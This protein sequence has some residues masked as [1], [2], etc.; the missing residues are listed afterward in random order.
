MPPGLHRCSSRYRRRADRGWGL[1][2]GFYRPSCF[3]REDRDDGVRLNAIASGALMERHKIP[4]RIYL[5]LT[6][7]VGH[8]VWCP[9]GAGLTRVQF[10]VA[11]ALVRSDPN[12]VPFS[13]YN[14]IW[15]DLRQLI[16]TADGDIDAFLMRLKEF[17]PYPGVSPSV[18]YPIRTA[19]LMRAR[20]I[21]LRDKF[22]SR[23]PRLN[24]ADTLFVGGAFW[25]SRA[26]VEFCRE[27]S[28]K[29]VN[30]VI[31]YHDLIPITHPEFTGHDF[32][33]EYRDVLRLRAHCIV[34]T[35]FNRRELE[36]VR[37]KMGAP[38]ETRVSV[39]PLAHEFPGARRNESTPLRPSQF[40]NLA[41]PFVLSVG[42]IEVRKNHLAL[43]SVWGELY[44]EL[45]ESLPVLVVAGRPGWKADETLR[46]LAAPTSAPIFFARAPSE[47]ALRWLYSNCLFTIFPSFFEGWGLPVGESLWFGKACAAS[48]TSSIPAVG[49]ELCEYF[50]PTDPAQMKAAVRRLLDSGPRDAFERRIRTAHLRTW[51]EV[52]R[53]IEDLIAG[54]SGTGPDV[55]PAN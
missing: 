51:S 44:A 49:G 28:D 10:E 24:A 38:G 16:A 18:K 25:M 46:K 27:A 40:E 31:L 47:Q 15:R 8:A 35:S 43:L 17:H 48:N 4:P 54:R 6:D 5:D 12:V 7:M 36:T 13:L 37:K 45:G 29:G 3:L 32:A 21:A 41:K 55:E 39:V 11:S 14:D 19:K 34:T 1:D 20:L 50:S 52:A 26:I 53:D 22:V 42:T 2:L 30:L 23:K 9:T 33:R